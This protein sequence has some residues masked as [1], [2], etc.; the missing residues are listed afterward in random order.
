M[1]TKEEFDTLIK[2]YETDKI[3]N[4]FNNRTEPLIVLCP[5]S[6]SWKEQF[7]SKEHYL[8]RMEAWNGGYETWVKYRQNI[9]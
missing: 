3:L 4:H 8:K 5:G 9:V 2:V 1:I 6:G 7:N